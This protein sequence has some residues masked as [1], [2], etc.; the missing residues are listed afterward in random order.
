MIRQPVAAGRFY[1]ASKE[2]LNDQ[3]RPMSDKGADKKDVLAVIS[4]H[5]GYVYSGPVACRVFSNIHITDSVIILGP[6]HT[7]IGQAFAVYGRG[8]WHTPMGDIGIDEELSAALCKGAGLLIDDASAHA[9]E[10]SIEVQ[11]PI[12]QYFRNDFRIVP[13]VLSE[14]NLQQCQQ[15]ASVL[16]DSIKKTKKNILIVASSDMTH[17]EPQDKAKSKDKIAIDAIL[18]LDENLLYEVVQRHGISMCGYVPVM[19]MLSAVKK[20]GA[21]RAKLITYSTSGDITGDYSSVVGYAG[22]SIE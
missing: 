1:P 9:Y 21:K 14:G 3:I 4:P 20:L 6:N 10:H 22:I 11:L 15:I 8:K 17:Y 2:A 19:V 5:A 16:A 12:M 7:G 13:I 18:E